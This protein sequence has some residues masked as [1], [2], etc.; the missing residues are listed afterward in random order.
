MPGDIGT[1]GGM[2]TNEH[3]QVV[4]QDDRPIEGLYATG[5]GTA[6]VMGRHYLGPGASIANTMVFGYVAARHA[7]RRAPTRF[8]MDLLQHH[9]I[10]ADGDR[11]GGT[12]A[13]RS[14]ILLLGHAVKVF[15]D[16]DGV[17]VQ[18]EGSWCGE[19]A[20]ARAHADVAVDLDFEG[21]G[22]IVRAPVRRKVHGMSEFEDANFFTD[23]SI[24]DDPYPYFD[25]VRDQSPVWRE[26]RYGMFIVTGHQE[27]MAIYGDPAVF[28][29]DDAA[30]G[31]VL[32]VQRRVRVVREILRTA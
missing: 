1:C 19:H 21:H 14:R 18:L 5:N 4:D 27:A 8:M 17:V 31:H 32:V 26:P 2:V 16:R 20:V 23:R 3:A 29:P 25:W 7:N 28:P 22:S 6:T 30:D 12:L 9:A 24:Q 11:L 13:R 15:D 10:P